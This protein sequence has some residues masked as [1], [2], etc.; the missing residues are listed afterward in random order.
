MHDA[1]VRFLIGIILAVVAAPVHGG[2][3]APAAPTTAL[4]DTCSPSV[5]PL[6]AAVLKSRS[7]WASVVEDDVTHQFQGDA[8][9]ANDRLIVVLRAKGTGAEVYSQTAGGPQRRFSLG[10]GPAAAS[11]SRVASLK[12]LENNPAAVVL[13]A[14]FMAADRTACSLSYRLTAGQAI[15]EVRPGA[16]ADRLLVDCSARY[17]VVPDFFGDDM[18]FQ[19]EPSSRRRLRLPAENFFLNLVDR[20]SAQVMCV[21][22]SR[23]QEAAAIQSADPQPVITGCEIQAIK[24]KSLWVAVL[25]GPDV[26]HER[27]IS[28]EDA[29]AQVIRDWKPPFPGKWRADLL[30]GDGLAHSWYF[31]GTEHPGE[32]SPKDRGQPALAAGQM[33]VYAMD[34]TRATPLT[35]FCPI[36]VL[37][38]TLG[39]GPC[40]YI[41]QTEGLATDANPTPDNAMTWIETQFKRKKEKTAAREIH[42]LLNQMVEHVGLAQAR[43]ERYGQLAHDTVAICKA[44]CRGRGAAGIDAIAH[45]AETLAKTVAASGGKPGPADRAARLAKQIG[46]LAGKTTAMAECERIGTDLRGI[47]AAQDRTLSNCRMT[48]RWIKQSALTVGEDDPQIEAWA[49]KIVARVEQ[50]LAEK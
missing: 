35:T 17:V 45:L 13:L 46:G 18:I 22:Q 31:Q 12:V 8:V 40:Q 27:A 25:E 36:D 4:F 9:I 41:L 2:R 29:K 3:D 37:R 44:E 16:G 39:V 32:P 11:R 19:A 38:N 50:D 42:G 21:W 10:A 30:E 28:A 15:V 20:G 43:I 34:R 48:A 6:P 47:G 7:G 14:R 33:V 49:R 5:G 1:T 23:K 26:W 24:D